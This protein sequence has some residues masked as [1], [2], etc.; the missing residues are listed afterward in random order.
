VIQPDG[1]IGGTTK[2]AF[3]DTT[4]GLANFG[5]VKPGRLDG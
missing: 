3:V 4:S 1:S 2:S 5:F